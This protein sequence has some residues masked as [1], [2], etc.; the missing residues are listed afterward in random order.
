MNLS[1]CCWLK[2][3]RDAQITA[4]RDN[5]LKDSE[6]EKN[7]TTE[8]CLVLTVRMKGDGEK[9]GSDRGKKKKRKVEKD[10]CLFF[11]RRGVGSH[12]NSF[13]DGSVCTWVFV[14]EDSP[15]HET[16]RRRGEPRLSRAAET[17]GA[18]KQ[19]DSVVCSRSLG[20]A[21]HPSFF[22]GPD[23]SPPIWASPLDTQ[24]KNN[25]V[26]RKSN[27]TFIT[28]GHLVELSK[29][30]ERRFLQLRGF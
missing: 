6:G 10:W 4:W 25:S 7:R 3:E 13:P 11:S 27:S 16:A 24:S 5:F 28:H 21:R 12:G 26:S 20:L 8:L 17:P 15:G 1:C 18:L 2:L 9:R 23:S 30:C 14:C 19:T 29:A 22:S